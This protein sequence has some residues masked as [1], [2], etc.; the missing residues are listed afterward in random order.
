MTS[1]VITQAQRSPTGSLQGVLSHLKAS[2]IA[3][4]V[5]KHIKEQQNTLKNNSFHVDEVI[6]GCV[7][8]AGMGQ[9]P[10]RQATI[11]AG[12][13]DTVSATTINKVC[14]SA[15]KAIMLGADAIRLNNKMCILAGGMESMSQA[16]YLL[17]KA[18]TGYRFGHSD[19]IDHMQW[20]GLV[21]AY[22]SG[23]DRGSRKAM[24]CF[25]DATAEKHSF[26]R[27]DQEKFAIETFERYQ[28]AH[29][30]GYFN[31]EIVPFTKADAV[32]DSDEPPTKVKP[33]KF[34]KLRPAFDPNG[35]VTAAT[36]SSIADGASVLYL[37]SEDHARTNGSPSLARIV[38]YTSFAGAPE[39]F[40]TAPIGAIQKLLTQVG[41]SIGDV[42]LFEVNEA[43]AVVP[44]AAIKEL[45]LDRDKVNIHGGACALGHPIGAS[46]ARIL[47][48]LVHAL[49]THGLKRGIATACIGGGEATA[50]AVEVM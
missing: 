44:M 48:T 28:K 14:G 46:G 1:V 9:A 22:H 2:E 17:T 29:T 30:S 42:D 45:K 41:W 7:L 27:D 43:F 8:S 23:N 16:P 4:H 6:L 10:A 11:Y 50:I 20:D 37:M 38:G 47:T 15:M 32:I 12:L 33:E 18:R 40:T 5:I 13:G 24:G 34:P 39:W 21:D 26:S 3:A 31:N 49:K 35:T 25:A 36:S 19:I